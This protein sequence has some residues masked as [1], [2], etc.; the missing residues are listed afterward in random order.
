MLL[1][2]C[3][4]SL[5]CCFLVSE[6]GP[7]LEGGRKTFVLTYMSIFGCLSVLSDVCSYPREYTEEFTDSN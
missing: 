7:H 1:F 2:L 3:L 4:F 6:A 5:F